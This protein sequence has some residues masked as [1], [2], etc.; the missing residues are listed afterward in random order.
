MPKFILKCKISKGLYDKS[1]SKVLYS[2]EE[3]CLPEV[4]ENIA[5][6]LRG[7]GYIIDGDLMVVKEGEDSIEE[8]ETLGCDDCSN[9][10]CHEDWHD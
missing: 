9:C 7:C 5:H 8:C 2:F 1:S 3:D 6:F 4:L 10:K